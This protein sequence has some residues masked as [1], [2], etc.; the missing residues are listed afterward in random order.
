MC[1]RLNPVF[2]LCYA[3]DSKVEKGFIGLLDEWG[4]P[5]FGEIFFVCQREGLNLPLQHKLKILDSYF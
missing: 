2:F 3:W 5:N 4:K 1:E